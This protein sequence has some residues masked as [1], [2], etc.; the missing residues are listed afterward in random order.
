MCY[1]E[2][3]P[4]AGSQSRGR[5]RL[6]RLHNTGHFF[7]FSDVIVVGFDAV[8]LCFILVI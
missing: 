5:S 4:G 3:E 7:A 1:P 8:L 6:D 2:P